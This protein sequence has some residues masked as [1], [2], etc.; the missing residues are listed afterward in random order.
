VAFEREL[1]GLGVELLAVME[2]D[3]G[4]QLDGDGLAVL[5]GLMAERELRTTLSFWSMSNSLSQIDANTMR[6]T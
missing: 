3:V 5:R 4:P 1:G 2:F 6:P